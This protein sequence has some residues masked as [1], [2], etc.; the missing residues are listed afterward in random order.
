MSATT[1]KYSFWREIVTVDSVILGVLLLMNFKD[2][3]GS[4]RL[5]ILLSHFGITLMQCL[6]YS[7]NIHA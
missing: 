1:P 2:L 6:L 7:E 5:T 4:K 3:I